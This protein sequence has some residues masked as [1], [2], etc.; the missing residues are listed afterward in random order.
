[1]T[2]ASVS[3]PEF[4]R[5]LSS[6]DEAPNAF[7]DARSI[8]PVSDAEPGI[9]RGQHFQAHAALMDQVVDGRRD[10]ELRFFLS[11]MLMQKPSEFLP[12]NR[13][14]LRRESPGVQGDNLVTGER[15]RRA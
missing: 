9:G 4:L 3:R 14:Q 7:D 1:M 10:E 2:S 15:M 5:I 11:S 13:E 8:L 12:Q 6:R